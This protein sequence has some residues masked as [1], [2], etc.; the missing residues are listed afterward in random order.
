MKKRYFLLLEVLIALFILSLCM[1]PLI[2]GPI[3]FYKEEVQKLKDLEYARATQKALYKIR[4]NLFFNK[5]P[6]KD[7]SEKKKKQAFYS[8]LKQKIEIP[9][10]YSEEVDIFYRIY[11]DLEKKNKEE[12]YRRIQVQLSI[13]EPFRYKKTYPIYH[14]FIKKYS[15]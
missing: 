11:T 14:F 7:F 2:R 15:H 6:W 12:I 5:I 9:D 13:K 1:T 10:I 3:Y 4:K 8:S